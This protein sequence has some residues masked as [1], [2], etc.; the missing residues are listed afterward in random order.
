MRLEPVD[1]GH[2]TELRG[3]LASDPEAWPI[4]LT[5]GIGEHFDSYWRAMV[6]TPGRIT[7]AARALASDA[8][9]GTSSFLHIEPA[10]GT[11]EIGVTF[12]APAHRGSAVNPQSKLLMLGEAFEAGARRVQFSIDALNARSQAAV[13]K[14]GAKREGVLR[15]HRVTWTGRVRDTAV[16]SIVAD[17]WPQVR[18]GLERRLAAMAA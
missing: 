7:F 13:L 4:L 15:E 2:R 3:V 1:E 5:C 10:H 6:D 9:V 17:E 11:L 14:L 18:D 8:I 12:F 16:F